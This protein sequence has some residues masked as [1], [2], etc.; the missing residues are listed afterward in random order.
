MSIRE[1]ILWCAA[2]VSGV[3]FVAKVFALGIGPQLTWLTVCAPLA[4]AASVY[5]FI[6]LC[7]YIERNNRW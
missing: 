2:A 4:G 6:A 1:K 3:L 7:A 5:G